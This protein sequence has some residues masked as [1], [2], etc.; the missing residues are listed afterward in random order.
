MTDR[1]PSSFDETLDITKLYRGDNVYAD[2]IDK[3]LNN[4]Q[5]VEEAASLV[6]SWAFYPFSNSIATFAGLTFNVDTFLQNGSQ[7]LG[8][9]AYANV[10]SLGGA[11]CEVKVFSDDDATGETVTFTNTSYSWVHVT[12]SAVVTVGAN[13]QVSAHVRNSSGASEV[14]YI[15]GLLLYFPTA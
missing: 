7:S 5:M 12:T 8:L 13:N 2:Q 9:E 14:A 11:N 15:T 10:K 6:G 3:V 4:Q 1:N